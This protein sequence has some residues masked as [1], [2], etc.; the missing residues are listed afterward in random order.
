[1][2]MAQ[3]GPARQER[4]NQE[5]A[6]AEAEQNW[7]CRLPRVAETGDFLSKRCAERVHKKRGFNGH[8]HRGWSWRVPELSPKKT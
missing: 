4:T 6:G 3:L 1:M 5:S 2:E 7:L 8:H